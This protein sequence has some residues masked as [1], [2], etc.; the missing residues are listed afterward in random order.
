MSIKKE[1]KTVGGR[2]KLGQLERIDQRLHVGETMI[3]EFSIVVKNELHGSFVF[4]QL[5]RISDLSKY[6]EGI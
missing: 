2:Q 5:K 1:A 6:G 3:L 4:Q